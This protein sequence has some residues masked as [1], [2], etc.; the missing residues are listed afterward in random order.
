MLVLMNALLVKA[1]DCDN[2]LQVDDLVDE[3]GEHI[4]FKSSQVSMP[5]FEIFYKKGGF[6]IID[7]MDFDGGIAEWKHQV[8]KFRLRY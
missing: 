6:E 2:D 4:I 8:D 7:E 1:C 3:N 5:N